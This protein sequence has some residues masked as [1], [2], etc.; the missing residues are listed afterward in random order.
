M[1]RT[2]PWTTH[3]TAQ[4]TRVF[5]WAAY[6]RA[7][8][9]ATLPPITFVRLCRAYA[10]NWKNRIVACVSLF[11]WCGLHQVE[12][13]ACHLLL[14]PFCAPTVHLGHVSALT[15]THT[16]TGLDGGRETVVYRPDCS[17]PSATRSW[18]A[19]YSMLL[20]MRGRVQSGCWKSCLQGLAS[21]YGGSNCELRSWIGKRWT[22]HL[23]FYKSHAL[24]T[25]A[26]LDKIWTVYEWSLVSKFLNLNNLHGEHY[27]NYDIRSMLPGSQYLCFLKSWG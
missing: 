16:Q 20:E 3:W 14:Q 6:V 26:S 2:D 4:P 21:L 15:H 11:L 13:T 7:T 12:P 24:S 25:V 1:A 19:V 23:S 10:D 5:G 8:P 27:N 9:P 17:R 18:C 22:G